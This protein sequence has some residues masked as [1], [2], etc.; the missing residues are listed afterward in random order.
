MTK[1][2]IENCHCLNIGRVRASLNR[3]GR[4][5]GDNTDTERKD[6]RYE[7]KHVGELT[8]LLVT[9][10]GHEPQEIV[11]DPFETQYGERNYL[12]CPGC[13]TKRCKLYLKP[14]GHVFKCVKCHDLKYESFNPRSKQGQFLG[15]VKKV[16]KLVNKQATMTSRIWYRSVYTERY[17]KFLDDCLKAGLTDVVTEAR[18]LEASIKAHE[19]KN[20][21]NTVV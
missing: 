11:L 9:L 18:A 1:R 6:I 14:E 16:L 19:L 7:F 5:I 10:G 20:Q 17:E 4:K 13:G 12:R 3:I 15:H 21:T 2:F 8:L